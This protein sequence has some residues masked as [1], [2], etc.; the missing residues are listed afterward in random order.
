MLPRAP[1]FRNT[2]KYGLKIDFS[3]R[4]SRKTSNATTLLLN[5]VQAPVN[6]FAKCHLILPDNDFV[7]HIFS[8]TINKNQG[9]KR[10][11]T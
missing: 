11:F 6:S 9:P 2:R 7:L 4:Q 3:I 10:A 1:K 8:I 5:M